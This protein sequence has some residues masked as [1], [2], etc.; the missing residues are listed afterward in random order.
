MLRFN[1]GRIIALRGINNALTFLMK[2]GFQRGTANNLLNHN[3][4]SI[5]EEHLERLCSLLRCTPNDPFE[6]RPDSKMPVSDDHPLHSLRRS[7][8]IRNPSEFFKE[9]PLEKLEEAQDILDRLK[10]E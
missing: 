1:P 3:N 5:K 2:N 9:L 6:W 8:E 7:K 10:N 4:T